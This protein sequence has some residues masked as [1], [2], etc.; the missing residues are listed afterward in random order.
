MKIFGESGLRYS[1]L[2][3]TGKERDTENWVHLPT[4]LMSRVTIL[5]IFMYDF[6]HLFW[7]VSFGELWLVYS[8]DSMQ[9]GSIFWGERE[10][11]RLLEE[12]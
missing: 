5:Q 1:P 11:E 9:E 2:L 4:F 8:C 10:R 7:E 3:H 12:N 6:V